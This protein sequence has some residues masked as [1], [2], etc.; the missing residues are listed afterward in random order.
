MR[1]TTAKGAINLSVELIDDSLLQWSKEA[2]LSEPF[3][4]NEF[5]FGS[6]QRLDHVLN[7]DL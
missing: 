7:S 2:N 4:G 6:V 1:K 3:R 5:I